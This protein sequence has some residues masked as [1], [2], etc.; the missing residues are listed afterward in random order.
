MAKKNIII[1]SDFGNIKGGSSK[2]A[3][4]SAN[5][6]AASGKYH[7][8]YLCGQIDYSNTEL[9]ARI[10]IF[11]TQ[12][13]AL[14]ELKNKIFGLFMG[15][16]NPRS[17]TLLKTLIGNKKLGNV[18]VHVHD[19]TKILSPSILLLLR[20]TGTNS[21]YTHHDYG[22]NCP[23]GT[24]FHH[25]KS[26]ICNLKG[27][28]LKCVVEN[29][30]NQNYRYKLF[31][32]MRLALLK[33]FKYPHF[34]KVNIF[35]NDKSMRLIKPGGI[36]NRIVNNFNSEGTASRI[37]CEN[38]DKVIFLGRLEQGKGLMTISQI[39]K[40]S[41][42]LIFIGDGPLKSALKK[43]FPLAKF[44]GWI[45][46]NEIIEH[47]RQ[48]RFLILP[49]IW[50]EVQPL[51]IIEAGSFGIP[52]LVN[53]LNNGSLMVRDSVDGLVYDETN[54]EK[55]FIKLISDNKVIKKYSI[56]AYSRYTSSFTPDLHLNLLHKIYRML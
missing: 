21:I 37:E 18:Y 30:D 27:L 1:V 45:G 5:L 43:E 10:N 46:K 25:K 42:N 13:K 32:Y 56:E 3:I 11:S 24:F 23:N 6:L 35:L 47:F 20:M 54:M 53:N 31:K 4:E 49:S 7:V 9:D 41:K 8:H 17:Y 15:L 33:L 34:I 40:Y 52:S 51:A 2:V 28:G 29:C 50:Y 26:H 39:Q 38:N 19:W 48:A 14:W 44:T 55:S 36:V 22:A 12:Q 16:W